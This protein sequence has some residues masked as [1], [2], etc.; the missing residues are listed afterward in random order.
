MG[1]AVAASLPHGIVGQSFSANAPRNGKVD[2]YP[3]SGHLTT[4]AQAEGAIEGA[5]R[6]YQLRSAHDTR[7]A[8]S[9]FDEAMQDAEHAPETPGDEPAFDA[10]AS[11]SE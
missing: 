6:D 10:L 11:E 1:A 4:S 2:S 8:F 5:A 7:F 9:R 3:P